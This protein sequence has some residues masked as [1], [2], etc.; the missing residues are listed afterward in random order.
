MH[1]VKLYIDG[2]WTAAEAGG[3]AGIVNPATEETIGT[4]AMAK[5]ADLDRAL[6]AVDRGFATWRAT[7]PHDRSGLLRRAAGN[8]RERAE[9]IARDIV[10]EEGKPIAEARAEVTMSAEAIEWFAEEARRIYGRLVQPRSENVTQVMT[11][12]PIGPVAAFTPWNYPVSQ[13]VRKISAALSAGCSIIVKGPEDTPIS[14]AAL[15]DCF[16]AAGVPRGV[17][18]LVYGVPAEISEYLVPHPVIRKVS[19]TG[20]TAV[21]KH[22][23]G[24]AGNNMKPVTM[25]LGGHAPAVVFADCDL[26]N[27]AGLLTALKYDN[28]GQSCIAPTRFLI[29]A[30][31]YDA[32]VERFVKA[33][34]GIRIGNGLEPETGMGPMLDPRRLDANDRF[35]QDAA[36]NGGEI[37]TGGERLGNKGYFYTPTVIANASSAMAGM[38]EEPF[39]PLAFLQRFETYDQVAAEINRLDYGL[40]SFLFTN[41]SRTADRF[42]AEVESGMVAVNHFGLALAETPFGGMKDS[43]YGSE[44]GPEAIEAYLQTKFVTRLNV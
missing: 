35:T 33:S 13:A 27:A 28:A 26:E 34:E 19:F 30:P 18:N 10:T 12:E 20:S 37:L 40:A 22:L 17:L 43:G 8:L 32:F 29:E 38:N 25:E 39:G 24:L 11:K 2:D 21:G 31:V 41:S 7:A 14:C 6:E 42:C 36:A 16:H 44:C 9:E 15:V 5:T 4:V 3:E 23:A 1:Q